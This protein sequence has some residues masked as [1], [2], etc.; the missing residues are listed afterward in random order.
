MLCGYLW[1][2]WYHIYPPHTAAHND[3]SMVV[4]SS[5]S[6]HHIFFQIESTQQETLLL[7]KN[8]HATTTAQHL[9]RTHS[10]SSP[11]KS[12]LNNLD[13]KKSI[14]VETLKKINMF[15]NRMMS[16]FRVTLLL[17]QSLSSPRKS[18]LNNLDKKK[19][20]VVEA[21]QKQYVCKQNDVSIQGHVT[22]HTQSLLTT[23][24]F[25]KYSNLDKKKSTVVVKHLK[26]NMFVNR[27]MSRCH[28]TRRFLSSSSSS[29]E[30]ILTERRGKVGWIT[31]NRPKALN[32]N[33]F[34]NVDSLSL[35]QKINLTT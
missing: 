19:S 10:L 16:R 8:K 34:F 2:V 11:R 22:T 24:I 32:G 6:Y 17:T 1:S 27:M 21:L 33:V 20:S 31:L 14:V 30:H 15:V 18:F 35:C 5:L 12:F 29:Y 4:S 23:K 28:V 3:A 26:N 13:K 9:L 25:S 7:L